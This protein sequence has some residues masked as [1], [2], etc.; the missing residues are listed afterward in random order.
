MAAAGENNGGGKWLAAAASLEN[1][2]SAG[3][4]GGIGYIGRSYGGSQ[5]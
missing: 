1:G 5:R 3:E 4:N 2:V